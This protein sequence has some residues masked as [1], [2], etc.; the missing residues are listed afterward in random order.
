MSF[1]LIENQTELESLCKVLNQRTVL[2]IDTEFVRQR[3]YYPKIGLIQINCGEHIYLI[4][5]LEV[6]SW[7]SFNRILENENI[8]KVIHSCSEDVEVF[9]SALGANVKGFYDTQIAESFCSGAMSLGLAA[10]V[11]QYK[12]IQLDKG[13]AR[14]DW[15]QRPLT[16]EQLN[17]AASDVLY[18]LDIYH[19]QIVTLG[20]KYA[21]AKE[22]VES[23]IAKKYLIPNP[24]LA[25]RDIKSNWLLSPRQLA[26]LRLLAKWRLENAIARDMAINFVIHERSIIALATR[27]PMSINSMKNVPDIH[28]MEIR[29]H[30][31]TLL[32]FIE[33]GKNVP[34]AECPPKVRRLSELAQYK[35]LYTEAKALISEIA[36]T[37]G[38]NVELLASKRQIN[39]YISYHWQINPW[40]QDELPELGTG[41]RG[42][43]LDDALKNIVLKG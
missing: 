1:K 10:L 26:V 21:Q 40:C 27:Q 22:D 9:K 36:Q 7:Q 16:P 30:G 2:A 15:L 37:V 11:N 32:E 38:I 35:P 24:D 39:Q 12:H 28:P 14:T 42:E 31:N 3:T 13:H 18:L 8:I 34:I 4:D 17:Y 41:W 19:L 6:E 25:W 20:Q 23:V 5:P 43:L 29:K 33:Q